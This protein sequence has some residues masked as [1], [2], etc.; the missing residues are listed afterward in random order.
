MGKS[1]KDLKDAQSEPQRTDRQVILLRGDSIQPVPV[2]W[3]WHG[4]LALGKFHILAG[5][6]G[7]GKTGIAMALAAPI[8]TGGTWPDGSKVPLGSVVMWSGEDSPDDVLI[9]RLLASGGDPARMHIVGGVSGPRGGVTPFDPADDVYLLSEA[10]RAIPDVRMLIVDP[11]VSA[12]SGDSHKNAE[13]RRGLQP[14]VDMA[15]SHQF[16]LLG[17]THFTKGTAGQDPVDRV[18][19]SLAFG[20][21]ARVVTVATKLESDGSK[22]TR[23]VFMRAKSNIGP[24]TGGFAYEVVQEELQRYPGVIPSAV[25][26]GDAI[27]GNARDLL[28]QAE[29]PPSDDRAERHGA[30]EW[31]RA[32]LSSGPKAVVDVKAAASDAGWAWRTVQRAMDRAGVTSRR[33]GFGGAAFWSISEPYAPLAPRSEDGAYGASEVDGAEI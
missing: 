27:E 24:D 10:M 20:A 2:R 33:E 31:L 28:G 19:G 8:T 17:I 18:T 30:T 9:P 26:W 7:S 1:S 4:W 5:P 16:A 23:R 32:I 15:E 22:L 29:S 14:L 13:T 6:P 12:I 25:H 3:L 21:M 11:I